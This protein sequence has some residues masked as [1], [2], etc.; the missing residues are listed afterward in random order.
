[1]DLTRF[2]RRTLLI[3]FSI[4]FIFNQFL[5]AN[6]TI[7]IG[8]LAH[9]GE[10]ESIKEW[11]ATKDYLNQELKNYHFVLTPVFLEQ[12]EI[13]VQ[14]KKIDLLICNPA[15]YI[16]LQEK[17]GASPIAT[18]NKYFQGKKLSVFGGLFFTHPK[19][20]QINQIS[21][22]RGKT[23]ALIDYQF[24]G[25]CVMP[26]VVLRKNKIDL[27]KEAGTIIYTHNH[28]DV[29]FEV[30]SGRADIGIVKSGVVENMASNGLIDLEEI[31]GLQK[32]TTP[33]FPYMLS[34]D[35]APEWPLVK[36]AHVSDFL[37]VEIARKLFAFEKA[38]LE[39][40]GYGWGIAADYSVVAKYLKLIHAPP[41]DNEKE[42][43][44]EIIEGDW[45]HFYLLF[46]L[47][48]VLGL[49]AMFL[50]YLYN[51]MNAS[52]KE[53]KDYGIEHHLKSDSPYLNVENYFESASAK[54]IF[55]L[56]SVWS[57]SYLKYFALTVLAYYLSVLFGL[58]FSIDTTG[59][60]AIWFASGVGFLA[61]Y[62]FG[63]RIWP[64]IFIGSFLV[65]LSDAH[66]VVS[67]I[68]QWPFHGLAAI[69]ALNNALEAVLAVF[70]SRRLIGSKALFSSI[71]STV[72]FIIPVSLTVSLFSATLGVFAISAF[73]NNWSHFYDLL[74]TWWLGDLAGLLLV[75][76]LVLSWKRIE[77]P[78]SKI[79]QAVLL[80]FFAFILILVGGFIF[81]IGYHIAYLFLPFFIYIT[82]RLGRF[83][84][85][86]MA[87]ILSIVSIW[88]VTEMNLFWLWDN[89]SEALFYV[90]LFLL[91][92]FLTI[93]L[94]AAVL[95]E[96]Y[97][98][99]GRMRL[100]KEI[101]QNSAE[102][103]A[104]LNPQG[105]YLEQNAA[106]AKLIGYADE[107]L[108]GK[109]PAIHLGT[110][111]FNS[112]FKEL[113]DGG[114]VVKELDSQTKAGIKAI[115]TTL[116]SIQNEA[117][118]LICHI[119]INRE[120]TDRKAVER[121]LRKSE[122]EAWSLFKHA[123]IPILIEDFS[124]IKEYIDRLKAAGLTNWEAYFEQNPEEVAKLA[125]KIKVIDLNEHMLDLH[126]KENK[127][128]LMKNTGH[129]FTKDSLTVFKNEIIALAQGQNSFT[130]EITI[131]NYK[132]Q[133]L[134]LILSVSIPPLYREKFERVLISFVDI[135]ENKRAEAIQKILLNISNAANKA[136]DI[137]Q[138]I[139]VVQKELGTIIDTSNFYLALYNAE[140]DEIELP[141]F[142]DAI[143]Q[144]KKV[145]AGN[146]LTRLVIKEGKSYLLNESERRKMH[147]QGIVKAVGASS[148]IWLGV[149][150]KVRDESI[151]AFVVQSYTDENAYNEKDKETMEI[152]ANQI[153]LTIERKKAE[154]D[155]NASFEKS[156]ESDRIKSAFL[157][158]MSH[159]LR[160]PLNAI[161][162][163]SGLMDN[164]L[165][166][167]QFIQ[168]AEMINRS[169]S[170]LLEIVDSIFEVSLIDSGA[171]P[172]VYENQS[173]QNLMDQIYQT[174]YIRR[175]VLNKEYVEISM[176][177][178]AEI[179]QEIFID[180]QVFK[181]IFLHLLNNALKFTSQGSIQFGLERVDENGNF[182]FYVKDTGIG[183]SKDKQE[184][185]FDSFRM[186]DDTHTRQYQGI[187]VGLFICKN[188]IH[189]LGGDIKLESTENEGAR[190]SF[191]LPL[192][193]NK[194][195]FIS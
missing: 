25:G 41:Y 105:F 17:Y 37:A 65:Y 46:G 97:S 138:T 123:A 104:V 100:Y 174:I 16:L 35:L 23:I 125:N 94:V 3:L 67:E 13:L 175:R 182:Y 26:K 74:L 179:A 98:A 34:T 48:I 69:S 194:T 62:I 54:K 22:L 2:S 91:I 87:V 60:T 40:S 86:L 33:G 75:V 167:D 146:T 115:E 153:A 30:L 96:Q 101:L 162:G 81:L 189:L 195:H 64:A 82:F 4:F 19:N 188:L 168:F 180:G 154:T 143:D 178:Q 49:F 76:P 176:N 122:A 42:T 53:K 55:Q 59:T 177:N 184:F 103:I 27:L 165:S 120:I 156:Q 92:L 126:G 56:H 135:T 39:N 131:Q 31:K 193:R 89:P 84:S 132:K 124:E 183:I 141:F 133:T 7:R 151:G 145:P 95:S 134:S 28:E 149:P 63:Y 11:T 93:L 129:F 163:F 5:Y 102:G 14:Q 72:L 170:N 50:R 152:V 147:A 185:I 73:G 150:L 24:V 38:G 110:D 109:T 157:S 45:Q 79:R 159:E 140:K 36:L 18:V 61:V 71:K 117:K 6:D 66:L 58:V 121:S 78:V 70:I 118:E 90:R 127:E 51:Q 29:V 192:Q 77:F 161:I 108:D 191:Y 142:K 83:V 130:S 114:L 1:M 172:I 43:F 190:F 148:K 171:H 85:L 139:E 20:E 57:Y 173:L 169:G 10:V 88:V 44:K 144:F 9:R 107:E 164:E 136:T 68:S 155:L 113:T 21:D 47:A 52:K 112:L 106:H 80:L 158:S 166:Q 186:G 116:F 32:Q 99:E 111:T 15:I 128:E 137:A 119:I 8:A 187:G 160:T 12:L 181:N